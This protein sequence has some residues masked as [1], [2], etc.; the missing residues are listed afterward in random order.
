VLNS[1]LDG[2]LED[3]EKFL[4]VIDRIINAGVKIVNNTEELKEELREFEGI[5]QTYVYDANFSYWFEVSEAKVS[6]KRGVNSKAP[7]SCYFTKELFIKILT[8]E[9]SGTDEFLK[10]RIRVD[11][12]LSQGLKYVKFHRLFFKYIKLKNG[13]NRHK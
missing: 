6:Y 13:N 11:G 4:S 12:D 3:D 2:I 5:Y 8:R 9:L 1:I 10:G 7:F